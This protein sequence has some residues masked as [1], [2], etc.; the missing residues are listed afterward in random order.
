MFD[1]LLK[2][3]IKHNLNGVIIGNLNKN[4]ID[5]DVKSEAPKEYHGGLSGKPCKNLSNNLIRKTKNEYGDKLT[6]IGCGGVLSKEDAMEK[7]ELGADLVQM[8]TGMIFE[9]PI[10]M[11]KIC[12]EY[13]N[14]NNPKNLNNNDI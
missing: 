10:L 3:I 14:K 7:F 5:L 6:I 11:K 4:Y 2:I 12:K 8:I 9:G 1:E 13:A